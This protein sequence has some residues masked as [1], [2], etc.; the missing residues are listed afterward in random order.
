MGAD[1][2]SGIRGNVETKLGTG[3]SHTRGSNG[4]NHLAELLP[5][6]TNTNPEIIEFLSITLITVAISLKH[7]A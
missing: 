5:H 2:D 7:L 3:Q 6:N 4:E 1:I